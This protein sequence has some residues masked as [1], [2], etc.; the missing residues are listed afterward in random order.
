M[1]GVVNH[2]TKRILRYRHVE[3]FPNFV[4]TRVWQPF[5]TAAVQADVIII[6]LSC[7]CDVQIKNSFRI[8][9]FNTQKMRICAVIIP[10]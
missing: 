10:L 4:F 7:F 6:C 1:H 5:C 9:Y 2:E 3:S 8:L